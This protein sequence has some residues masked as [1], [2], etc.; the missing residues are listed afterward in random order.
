MVRVPVCMYQNARC[1]LSTTLLITISAYTLL[2]FSENK[3]TMVAASINRFLC[4]CDFLKVSTIGKTIFTLITSKKWDILDHNLKRVLEG[5]DLQLRWRQLV[6]YICIFQYLDKWSFHCFNL[7]Y[8]F[9]ILLIKHLSKK[10]LSVLSQQVLS[11]LYFK[12]KKFTDF[13]LAFYKYLL[14][15]ISVLSHFIVIAEESKS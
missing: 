4:N 14:N 6:I 13:L 2:Q 3:A 5:I 9:T 1:V 11:Y 10:L 8:V 15:H 12:E 7:S